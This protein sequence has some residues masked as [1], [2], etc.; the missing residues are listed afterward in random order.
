MPWFFAGSLFPISALPTWLG[1][2]AK[3]LPLTHALAVMRYGLVDGR[4]TGLHDIWGMTNPTAMAALSMAV[5]VAYAA[6]LLSVSV[7]VFTKAA[8]R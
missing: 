4:A 3:A 5:V 1:A 2:V 7:R 6:L 8:V